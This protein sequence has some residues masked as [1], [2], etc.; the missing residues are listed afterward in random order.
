M[1]TSL[2]TGEHGSNAAGML[3]TA[4]G[5]WA[6]AG[7]FPQRP[8]FTLHF[9]VEVQP[10]PFGYVSKRQHG[11][12]YFAGFRIDMLLACHEFLVPRPKGL[13]ARVVMVFV[14]QHFFSQKTGAGDAVRTGEQKTR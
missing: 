4:S 13:Q 14:L 7:K 8:L 1:V 10:Y 11:W 2:K 12:F 5:E 9:V 6:N 3:A